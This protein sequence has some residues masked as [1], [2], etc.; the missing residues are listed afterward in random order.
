MEMLPD[1]PAA[2]PRVARLPLPPAFVG[3]AKPD[4]NLEGAKSMSE[5]NVIRA[6]KDDAYR[7]GLSAAELA[8]APANPAGVIDI[9]GTGQNDIG[10]PGASWVGIC[11]TGDWMPCSMID[12][13]SVV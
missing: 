9:S 6:W 2:Y 11:N 5:P 7:S 3:S 10:G 1:T 13:K 4:P 12:R 8:G